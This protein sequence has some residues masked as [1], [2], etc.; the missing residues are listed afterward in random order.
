MAC[1]RFYKRYAIPSSL[2]GLPYSEGRGGG[3][4]KWGEMTYDMLLAL[5]WR[6][7][8]SHPSCLGA[9]V[10]LCTAPLWFCI[11]LRRMTDS[12]LLVLDL[13]THNSGAPPDEDRAS[14][15]YMHSEMAQDELFSP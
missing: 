4:F 2:N 3:A 5:F 7:L 13:A 1:M 9:N 6:L 10:L 14:N 11:A 12:P 15:G 8:R